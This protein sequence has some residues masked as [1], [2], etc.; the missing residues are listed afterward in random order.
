[1]GVQAESGMSWV[2]V[3]AQPPESGLM[4]DV[5]FCSC[6]ASRWPGSPRQAGGVVLTMATQGAVPVTTQDI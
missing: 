5:L 3:S 6:P 2:L 4:S 1:M